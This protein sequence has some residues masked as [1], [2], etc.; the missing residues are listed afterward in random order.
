MS[1]FLITGETGVGKTQ[2]GL[3]KSVKTATRF[4]PVLLAYK[5]YKLLRENRDKLIKHYNVKEDEIC[6]CGTNLNYEEALKSYTNPEKPKYM[7]PKA[8]FILCTQAV[9]QRKGHLKFVSAGDHKKGFSSI[10]VD[11]FDFRLVTIPTLNYQ[12]SR[13]SDESVK[14]KTGADVIEWVRKSYSQEDYDK[15]ANLNNSYVNFIIADWLTSSEAP[16]TFLTSETLSARFLR[17][18]GFEQTYLKSP[19]YKNCVINTHSSKNVVSELFKVMNDGDY[20]SELLDYYDLIVSDKIINNEESSDNLVKHQII[21][22]LNHTT[23]RGTNNH[24]GKKL[25]TILSHVPPQVLAEIKDIF[26][27]FDDNIT[28]D[29]VYRMFYRDRLC[30]ALGRVLGNR[31]SVETDL[32]INESIVKSIMSNYDDFPYTFKLGF[33]IPHSKLDEIWEKTIA[34]REENKQKRQQNEQEKLKNKVEKTYQ[35]L[36]ELLVKKPDS[37]ISTKELGE[38][39]NKK[40][41]KSK[42]GSKNIPIS[43]VAL[44][45]DVEIKRLTINKVRTLYV[46][47][48][49]YKEG[50]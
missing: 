33:E 48:L 7:T 38:F 16:V 45:F 26:H 11:E 36:D 24:I 3:S 17:T 28:D 4:K 44:H 34:L 29:E 14:Y 19:N 49:D 35:T 42:Y 10:I 5:D 12:L 27:C 25:L 13:I 20:W 23:V 50:V 22:V 32:L 31:G 21:E 15:L 40:N 41:V 43:K 1:N 9:L 46:V 6:V 8:K 30:Q 39:L 18:L 37:Y 47:G 2:E